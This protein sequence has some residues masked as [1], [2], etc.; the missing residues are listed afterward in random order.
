VTPGVV[1]NGG[2]NV[3]ANTGPIAFSFGGD[4]GNVIEQVG[5]FAG[6]PFGSG[7]ITFVYQIEVT[8]G[9]ILNLTSESF[10][11]PGISIDVAQVAA[12]FFP[13]TLT[14]ATSAS[15]TSDK[16]TVGFGFT[17]PD[18]LMSGMTSYALLINTNL[19]SFEP[20]VFSLQDGQTQNFTGYVPSA[21]PEPS[22]LALLGTGLLGAAGLARRRIF[23]K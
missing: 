12:A 6:N 2:F 1:P 3:L 8:G 11:I 19:T 5:N 10:A 18:G 9:N 23:R 16:T 17:P 22:S 21:V 20:G 15:W 13:G 4:T 7:D 14:P